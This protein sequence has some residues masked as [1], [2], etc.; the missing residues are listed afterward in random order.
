MGD[1]R[2]WR[3]W[4]GRPVFYRSRASALSC[5]LRSSK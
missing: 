1:M 3:G 5:H 2:E 4:R